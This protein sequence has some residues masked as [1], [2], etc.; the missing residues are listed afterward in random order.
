MTPR[1]GGPARALR[2]RG[3][4]WRPRELIWGGRGRGRGRLTNGAPAA[5]CLPPPPRVPR[6]RWKGPPPR[7]FRTSA[8]RGR[9]R[10][11]G[12][13]GRWNGDRPRL[14]N[15]EHLS[16]HSLSRCCPGVASPK[17]GFLSRSW[18]PQVRCSWGQG[19]SPP[20]AAFLHD[21]R[22]F[23]HCV[24]ALPNYVPSPTS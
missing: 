6:G 12:Y 5:G 7:G 20:L 16:C 9:C 3:W 13:L 18:C 21:F 17:E 2:L 4:R 1:L 15:W 8:R 23:L 22:A 14:D 10:D 24:C 11:C 19:V